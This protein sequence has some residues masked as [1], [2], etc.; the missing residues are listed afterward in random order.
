MKGTKEASNNLVT[1]AAIGG[2]G[3]VAFGAAAYYFLKGNDQKKATP[4]SKGNALS[5]ELTLK[6]IGD[7]RREMFP[8]FK[9]LAAQSKG[10][11]EETGQEIPVEE[12]KKE[13]LQ[14]GNSKFHLS[15]ILLIIA[16]NRKS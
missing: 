6:L 1:Y 2:L 12:L 5:K 8:F 10:L 3:L 4:P 9:K 16:E 15:Q 7:L 13:I 14:Y 11:M